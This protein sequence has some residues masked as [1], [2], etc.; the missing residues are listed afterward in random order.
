MSPF[1]ELVL[2]IVRTIPPGHVMSYGQVALY[3]GKPGHAREAGV[4]MRTLGDQ[5]NFPWWRVLNSQGIVSIAGNPDA[6]AQ[7]QQELLQK[8]GIEFTKPF[9]LDMDRYR[10]YADEVELKKIGKDIGME[11][12]IIASALHKYGKPSK[13]GELGL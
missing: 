2:K 10:Y 11:D 12:W 9:H 8:E 1:E 6:N 4:A 7:M 3:A 5:P 13:T